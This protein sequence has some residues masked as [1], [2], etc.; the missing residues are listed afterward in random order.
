MNA[1]SVDFDSPNTWPN[2]NISI[3]LIACISEEGYNGSQICNG[4][5]LEVQMFM[6][7]Q[8]FVRIP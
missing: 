2:F 5:E 3:F 4:V 8:M 1:S 6:L 7:E